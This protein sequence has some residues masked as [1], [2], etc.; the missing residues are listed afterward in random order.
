MY[1]PR[2]HKTIF[3]LNSSKHEIYPAHKWIVGIL[4]YIKL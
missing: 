3:M 2:G 4:T 1:S